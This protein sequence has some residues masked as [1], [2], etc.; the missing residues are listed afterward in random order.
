MQHPSEYL[1]PS[2]LRIYQFLSQYIDFNWE[3]GRITKSTLKYSINLII[4][5]KI[6]TQEELRMKCLKEQSV[7]IPWDFFDTYSEGGNE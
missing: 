3:A 7:I 6:L 4:S 5:Q 2:Q 1:T